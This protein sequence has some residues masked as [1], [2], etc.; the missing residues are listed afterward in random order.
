MRIAV[1]LLLLA[2]IA[3][4]V[5]VPDVKLSVLST[6]ATVTPGSS[7]TI[8]L[9]AVNN[10][11]GAATLVRIYPDASKPFSIKE[12]SNTQALADT[13]GYGRSLTSDFSFAVSPD[14]LSDTYKFKVFAEYR[15][16]NNNIGKVS[17]E[18]SI[19]V[20]GTPLIELMGVSLPEKI[21][22]G[23]TD[24]L[25]VTIKNIG[26][27]NARN[28][29]VMFANIS[30]PSIKAS[31]NP[32]A[33]LENAPAGSEKTFSLSFSVDGK[34]PA[35]AY[36]LP[37][38]VSYQDKDGN[39]YSLLRL[40]S[41]SVESQIRLDAFS[42]NQNTLVAGTPGTIG[43]TVANVGQHNAEFLM[44]TVLEDGVRPTDTYIGTLDSNDYSTVDLKLTPTGSGEKQLR[45]R[46]A[47]RDQYNRGSVIEKNIS[48]S[49]ISAAEFA[50]E[51]PA[52]ASSYAVP[53]IVLLLLLYLV[54][55]KIRK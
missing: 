39:D 54:Y 24:T 31:G 25:Q 8:Q 15:D 22:P 30:D 17:Q 33:Y 44:L 50:K 34:A 35:K 45:V 23:D 53:A 7:F 2:S 38:I 51:Q 41:A 48:Y 49:I 6:P 29:R 42:S 46:L 40:A 27:A 1:F 55:R 28:V 11:L 43:V 13:L 5:D 14:A 37:V 26:T 16:A 3:L 9:Q 32:V 21:L 52:S 12:G 19:N 10:G 36:S 47:Y 18:V 20:A 4:A